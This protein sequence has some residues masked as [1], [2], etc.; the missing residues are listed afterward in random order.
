M[1]VL[2]I[3]LSTHNVIRGDGQGRVC[4]EILRR[5]CEHGI[6][7]V[8]AAHQASDEI[9]GLDLHCEHIKLRWQKPILIKVLEFLKKANQT[10]PHLLQEG[11]RVIGNGATYT[12]PHDLNIAHFV[13]SA[14]RRSPEHPT[15]KGA[16]LRRG[17][18]YAYSLINSKL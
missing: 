5:S 12:Y 1:L 4:L 18:D 3:V 10:I 9:N 8:V 2:R 17:Y 11:D 15:R 6:Q 14:W 7:C 16:A 13:H